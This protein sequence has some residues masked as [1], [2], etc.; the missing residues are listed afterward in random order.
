MRRAPL[1]ALTMLAMLTAGGE[2]QAAT[3]SFT[4]VGGVGIWHLDGNWSCGHVPTGSDLA[5][6]GS[7]DN[8]TVD[9][10]DSAGSLTQDSGTITFSGSS[11]LQVTV[12]TVLNAGTVTGPG[13]LR[14]A[15]GTFA[16][17]AG[18]LTVLNQARLALDAPG[19]IDAGDI[20][21]MDL[22]DGGD[23]QLQLNAALTIGAGAAA[24]PIHCNAGLNG[25]AVRIGAAGSLVK[26]AAGTTT[27]DPGIDNDGVLSV[28]A[29]TL[30]LS[31]ADDAT[32]A[33]AYQIAP[34][35][36]LDFGAAQG[37]TSAASVT[38]AGTLLVTA[39]NS[40]VAAGATFSPANLTPQG[41][42]STLTLAGTSP[43]YAPANLNMT[44]GRLTSTRDLAPTTLNA[45]SG[46]LSGDFTTTIGA[47]QT[48]TKNT[49]TLAVING[50]RLVLDVPVSLN[51]GSI[52][53][54]DQG[55][56]DPEL[57]INAALT[58]GAGADA[59]AIQ[60]NAGLDGPAVKI[61]AA[62]SLARSAAGTTGID[63]RLQVAGAV[64][65]AAGQTMH[66]S[67]GFTQTGGS[68]AIA[69]GA[70]LNSGG[71]GSSVSGGTLQVDGS[72]SGSAALTGAG[73]LT[74]TGTIA[75]TLT[76]TSGT[77]RP[78]SSPGTLT[79]SG[80]FTQGAGGTLEVDIAGTSPGTQFDVLAVSG[81]A[82]LDGTVAVQGSFDPQLAD[83]FQFLTSGSRSG[84][85]AAVTS[86]PLTGGKQYALDYPPGAPRGARL[87]LQPP[88][89]P[90]NTSPPTITGTPA[91]GQVLACAPGTWTGDPSLAFQWL[92]DGQPI[93]GATGA[94]Y[95]LTGADAGHQVACRVTGANAAGNAQATS[96]P[97]GI[98]APPAVATPPTPAP[99]PKPAAKPAEEVLAA[100]TADQ[101][102]TAL[103]L[104]PAR[105]CVSRRNFTIRVRKPP[106]V[107]I[108]TAK[109]LVNGKR[110]RTR[111]VA[112]RFTATVDLRGLPK[113]RFTVRITIAT[114]SGRKI[115][116]ARRYRTCA[117]RRR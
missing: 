17:G 37:L 15:S 38:G 89:A 63:P 22:V 80:G 109:V 13:T 34:G 92:R 70:T 88:Q 20:C 102:A 54:M 60:C 106:G 96:A 30:K 90:A 31:G 19:S 83:T 29:G 74:G 26:S 82:V 42:L 117:P 95:T 108:K 115:T 93:G 94:T 43:V 79:I 81:H 86:A 97:V 71:T 11:T 23:P 116:G 103:G 12:S 57:E 6:V 48:L 16:K 114:T 46:T 68:V 49:G 98:A 33:G 39:G 77:V 18:G 8:V 28:Q 47:G 7:G 78:G 27:I 58:I 112:G 44:G 1:L 3:C 110:V 45:G 85:F 21:L 73:V 52:C 75:G 36:T 107:T 14:A 104:P 59:T 99:T 61:G 65:V 51:A 56:G 55:G 40:T 105:R 10:D 87:V 67:G 91:A 62:G 69:S 2:A 32:S 100:K 101:I 53:L 24:A 35:A 113:G 72:H 66:L 41:G 64:N 84:A 111:K 50:A 5:V 76:N 25:P 4:G 9:Q